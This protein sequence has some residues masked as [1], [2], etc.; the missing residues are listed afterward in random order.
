MR[1]VWAVTDARM[2]VKKNYIREKTVDCNMV[3]MVI[4][5]GE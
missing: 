4:M 3:E 1:S 5:L 2:G